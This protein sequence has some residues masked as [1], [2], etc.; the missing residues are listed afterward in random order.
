[1]AVGPR[2]EVAREVE[3]WWRWAVVGD[4]QSGLVKCCFWVKKLILGEK[5]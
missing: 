1:M 5:N 3:W 4:R 2:G